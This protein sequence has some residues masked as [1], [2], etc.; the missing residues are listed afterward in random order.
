MNNE[1][2]FGNNKNDWRTPPHLFGEWN[3]EFH[4]TL[5]PACNGEV[6]ALCNK[7]YTPKEDGLKQSWAGE[8][9][10]VNPPYDNAKEWVKKAYESRNEADLIVMLLPS[11]T[12]TKY[13]H[14]YIYHK[15]TIRLLKGRIK[16]VGAKHCAPFQGYRSPD[17]SIPYPP[18]LC[19]LY[20]LC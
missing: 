13:F 19:H 2:M 3:K 1:V 15:S 16:F 18:S 17:R 12:D 5:D 6:D 8:R 14:E 9:V 20:R 4:F 10:Y 7:F 11:R